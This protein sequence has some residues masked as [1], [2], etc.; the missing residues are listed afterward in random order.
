MD[1]CKENFSKNKFPS[2]FY[3]LDVLRFFS[4]LNIIYYHLCEI[5]FHNN[6]LLP[7]TGNMINIHRAFL[8]LNIFILIAFPPFFYGL[9]PSSKDRW[10]KLIAL[11][12]LGH[13]VLFFSYSGTL[14][15]FYTSWDIFTFLSVSTF[16]LYLIK[17]FKKLIVLS[18]CMGFILLWMPIW[19][20]IL[21]GP[22]YLKGILVGSCVEAGHSEYIVFPI[23]PWIG[24]IW[25]CYGLGTWVGKKALA[26]LST[27]QVKEIFIWLFLFIIAFPQ[28]G[29]YYQKPFEVE[30]YCLALTRDPIIFWSHF[31]IILFF[32]RISLLSRVNTFFSQMKIVHWLCSLS[33]VRRFGI[34]YITHF[35]FL[36]LYQRLF[37]VLGLYGNNHFFEFAE[38]YLL[39]GVMQA[40]ILTEFSVRVGSYL[41]ERIIS[42]HR[43]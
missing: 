21:P 33:W 36:F 42:Q 11:I 13:I 1:I 31:I 20:W 39:I 22:S 28:W 16:S 3:C 24:L 4:I 8:V 7:I 40:L 27:W 25:F 5:F 10:K 2:R 34:C 26:I 35:V 43:C 14:G 32:I 18:F 30:I 41:K 17:R 23:F 12:L 9:K 15:T 29:G 38:L 19:K 37:S 6:F